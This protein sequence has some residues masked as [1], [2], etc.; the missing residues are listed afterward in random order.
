MFS[1]AVGF[2]E[3]AKQLKHLLGIPTRQRIWP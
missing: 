1:I 3:F 2:L